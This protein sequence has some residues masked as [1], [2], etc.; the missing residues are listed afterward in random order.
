MG[1]NW[2]TRGLVSDRW[3]VPRALPAGAMGK[4]EVST[5][6]TPWEDEDHLTKGFISNRVFC[7]VDGNMG[8]IKS[9]TL[10]TV[11]ICL[12]VIYI[13]WNAFK[14]YRGR[15][16]ANL[17]AHL[18]MFSIVLCLFH[19]T[20]N[21]FFCSCFCILGWSLVGT[22]LSG[23]FR[24]VGVV[25]FCGGRVEL[26][27]ERRLDVQEFQRNIRKAKDG[28]ASFKLKNVRNKFADLSVDFFFV[29]VI[30]FAQ[31][32]LFF[33][34][35]VF[36]NAEEWTK[37]KEYISIFKWFQAVL[38]FL[39]CGGDE[40][41]S[42]YD[43]FY[44]RELIFKK[45][46]EGDKK[47]PE[48]VVDLGLGCKLPVPLMFELYTRRIMS[49]ISNRVIRSIVMATAPILLSTVSPEDF[50]QNIVAFLWMLRVDDLFEPK[51]T[52]EVLE[53]RK[54]NFRLADEEAY[55]YVQR[56]N[57]QVQRVNDQALLRSEA[58]DPEAENP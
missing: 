10:F 55:G 14:P 39:I 56:V 11:V 5:K 21:P 16:R 4:V 42:D 12:S 33:I 27:N 51:T 57:D 25:K 7:F 47:I 43:G 44:W 23:L 29:I 45:A 22:T 30:F 24:C 53:F 49:F 26:S 38:I 54:D 20:A 17:A 52:D 3:R 2:W 50:V 1:D 19:L 41:G 37:K 34:Y 15:T 13:M 40:G 36:M 31:I 18:A 28:E 48:T 6:C 8:K 32:S 35:L 9:D 46:K 58:E